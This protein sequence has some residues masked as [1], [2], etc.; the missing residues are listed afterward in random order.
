MDDICF[1]ELENI[2]MTKK[3]AFRT[4]VFFVLLVGILWGLNSLF[5]HP[6]ADG[7]TARY[8]AFYKEEK[9]NTSQ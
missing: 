9:E 6:A 8:R 5:V 2:S 1:Y 7:T 4:A 3:Q